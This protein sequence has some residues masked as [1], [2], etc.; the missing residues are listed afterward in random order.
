MKISKFDWVISITRKEYAIEVYI[1]MSS[2][3]PGVIIKGKLNILLLVLQITLWD[4]LFLAIL[5]R[6]KR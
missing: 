3:Q 2:Y 1:S 4:T 6:K 5:P